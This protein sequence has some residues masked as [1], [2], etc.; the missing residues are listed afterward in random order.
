MSRLN[1]SP[2]VFVIGEACE[3]EGE[4]ESVVDGVAPILVFVCVWRK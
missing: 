1:C 4:K 2:T 3:E